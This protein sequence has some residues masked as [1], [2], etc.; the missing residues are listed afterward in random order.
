MHIGKD[1]REIK[2]KAL[3]KAEGY[4]ELADRLSINRLCSKYLLRLASCHRLSA[5]VSQ[6]FRLSRAGVHPHI[7]L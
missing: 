4:E 6:I 5:K 7:V 3:M 1:P 2:L